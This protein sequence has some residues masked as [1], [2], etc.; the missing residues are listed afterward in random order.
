MPQL[1]CVIETAR[2]IGQSDALSACLWSHT[3]T[4]NICVLVAR[5]LID[6]P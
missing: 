6:R 2:K 3:A 5:G 1:N 4:T